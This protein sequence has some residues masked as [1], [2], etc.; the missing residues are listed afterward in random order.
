MVMLVHD[1]L[2]FE[3]AE[4]E[5]DA[6]KEEVAKCMEQAASLSVALTVEAESGTHWDE[7][8]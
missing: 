7:P 4:S 3:V 6:F 2:V 8:H 1:E 5:L